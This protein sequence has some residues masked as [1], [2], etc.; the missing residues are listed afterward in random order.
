MWVTFAEFEVPNAPT[1]DPFFQTEYPQ[2]E[3]LPTQTPS[4][5]PKS[6]AL[7]EPPAAI[8]PFFQTEYPQPQ[9][10]MMQTP[11]PHPK[12]IALVEPA[13]PIQLLGLMGQAIT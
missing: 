13:A 9:P 12:S 1:Q 3:P 11:T 2:P 6:L 7:V 8:D 10:L 4:S 5:H